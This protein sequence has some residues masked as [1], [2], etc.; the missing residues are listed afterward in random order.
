MNKMNLTQVEKLM[1]KRLKEELPNC[2]FVVRTRTNAFNSTVDIYLM[3]AD[4]EALAR[5][6]DHE[7][8]VQTPV[9]LNSCNFEETSKIYSCNGIEFTPKAWLALKQVA[10]IIRSLNL[11]DKVYVNLYIGKADEPF[12]NFA[13]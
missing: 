4:F 12:E 10:S 5:P 8:F 3:S 11:G 9:P 13:P 6:A 1:R 7:F 2:K